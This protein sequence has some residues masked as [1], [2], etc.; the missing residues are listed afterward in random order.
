MPEG[1]E[2]HLTSLFI[3]K[4]C[5]DLIF[6]GRV[7]KN[8]IH[9]CADIDWDVPSY[10]ITSVSRGKE[11]IL[12]LKECKDNRHNTETENVENKKPTSKK[13]KNTTCNEEKSQLTK[14]RD[15]LSSSELNILF[16]FGMSG[17]FELTSANEC[18]KHSHLS[19]ITKKEPKRALSFIDQRRFGKWYVGKSW[20]PDRG[21]C[22][23]TEYEEFVKN[24]ANNLDDTVFKKPICEVMLNQKYFN[25]IGNYLRAEILYRCRIPPFERANTVLK[26]S[27]SNEDSEMTDV[28]NVGMQ[29]KKTTADSPVSHVKTDLL[30]D[31]QSNSHIHELHPQS[32]E[33]VRLCHT[34]PLEV[35]QLGCTKYTLADMYSEDNADGS[36]GFN[37][38]LQCYYKP[39][40][41]NM[42]DSN[43]RTIWFSGPAGPFAPT[44][45]KPRLKSVKSKKGQSVKKPKD[46]S[47]KS[48]VE[49]RESQCEIDSSP[50]E[51]KQEIQLKSDRKRS[52]SKIKRDIS[53]TAFKTDSEPTIKSRKCEKSN[54]TFE[55][56]PDKA[57]L[58]NRGHEK[59]SINEKTLKKAKT[60]C[61]R[62]SSQLKSETV[63][64]TK[65]KQTPRKSTRYST[66]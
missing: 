44:N 14:A 26:L 31:E 27:K 21:P 52:K 60:I 51:I 1:P 28:G 39:G 43:K 58:R 8:P 37:D 29:L 5:K 16:T 17:K 61:K 11:I 20:S 24:L 45:S 41:K 62:K 64:K 15:S 10:T 42:S 40:M 55:F 36:P 59:I 50:P 63:N 2:L 30:V 48:T 22:V 3:N 33:L 23:I 32:Q 65:N 35:V 66:V 19:F 57:Q 4:T 12:Q 53:Q 34:L 46:Q 54:E 6:S 56:K 47:K 13:R 49:R 9:K 38:W 7:L 18:P 25:G